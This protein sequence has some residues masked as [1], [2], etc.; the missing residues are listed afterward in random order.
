M[1]INVTVAAPRAAG[2]LTVFA[3]GVSRP[4][5]SNVNF[6]A[7]QTI[8]NLVVSQVGADGRIDLYNA[9]PGSVQVVGDVSGWFATGRAASGGLNSLRPAR[10]A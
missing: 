2:V 8:S 4:A 5:T 7:G 10:S 3:D 6:S 9:S 1:V